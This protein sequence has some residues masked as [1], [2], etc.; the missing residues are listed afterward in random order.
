MT[1][2]HP[3]IL[4]CYL[5]TIFQKSLGLHNVTCIFPKIFRLNRQVGTVNR[6]MYIFKEFLSNRVLEESIYEPNP[7]F[8]WQ[9]KCVI[10]S[11]LSL[12]INFTCVCTKGYSS[13]YLYMTQYDIRKLHLIG[14]VTLEINQKR[15]KC[16]YKSQNVCPNVFSIFWIPHLIGPQCPNSCVFQGIRQSK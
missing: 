16:V 9:I 7:Y 6:A 5:H 13:K 1:Y 11:N 3:P 4:F 14:L 8:G 15:C 12:D 10:K 2:I